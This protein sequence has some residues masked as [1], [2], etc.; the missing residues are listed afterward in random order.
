[1]ELLFSQSVKVIGYTSVVSLTTSEYP[2]RG[3]DRDHPSG[4]PHGNVR[5]HPFGFPHGSRDHPF[6]FPYG[7][8][9]DHP[10]GFPYG[11]RDHFMHFHKILWIFI[12]FMHFHK[13]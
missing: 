3:D 12:D 2:S 10:F 6:G 7:K 9:R 8:N 13:I 1:M 11:N 5:D 4:F